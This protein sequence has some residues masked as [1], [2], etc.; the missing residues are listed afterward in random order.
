[1]AC[2]GCDFYTL[3]ESTKAQLLQAKSN[4]RRRLASV[5]LT[6]DEEVAVDDG[7]TA[8]DEILHPRGGFH[9][10]SWSFAPSPTRG[11]FVTAVVA[12]CSCTR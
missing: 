5:P 1:M 2:A 7:Q 11:A 10:R 12:G 6:D 9:A 4:F 8:L 3:K